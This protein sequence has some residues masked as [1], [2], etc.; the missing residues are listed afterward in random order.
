MPSF[1]R[2]LIMDRPLPA[3]RAAVLDFQFMMDMAL[4]GSTVT[5]VRG[6][7][8]H[9]GARY[10]VEVRLGKGHPRSPAFELE[11]LEATE[12]RITW[13]SELLGNDGTIIFELAPEGSDRTRLRVALS[14]GEFDQRPELEPVARAIME[15]AFHM[16]V[17]SLKK[18]GTS[19]PNR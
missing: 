7:Q 10:R 3:M 13:S 6:A 18:S 14:Q 16:M 19:V 1:N 2:E 12:S 15:P 17:D 8:G 4:P 9:P 11:L 5:H